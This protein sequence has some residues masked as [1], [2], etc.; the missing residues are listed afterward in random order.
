PYGDVGDDWLG[1]EIRK[2]Q[3]YN[4]FLGTR[5]VVG[6]IEVFDDKDKFKIISNRSGIVNN[7]AFTQLT[8]STTP[9]GYYFKTFRRLERFVVEGIKWDSSSK[10]SA[11]I[12]K[13]ISQK[14]WSSEKEEY[15]E[16]EFTRNKRLLSV[17]NK[18]IDSKNSDVIGLTI[19]ENFVNELIQEE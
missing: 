19:N 2:G 6:R 12:E 7:V 14:G 17:I 8:R 3:G 9:Y 16:D 15:N 11:E 4:R 5:E 18:I 13:E 1:M 10:D